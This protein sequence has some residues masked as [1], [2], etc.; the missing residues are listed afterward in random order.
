MAPRAFSDI[1]LEKGNGSSMNYSV[2]EAIRRHR[3]PLTLVRWV[4]LLIGEL[5]YEAR[6]KLAPPVAPPRRSMSGWGGSKSWARPMATVR[7]GPCLSPR[8]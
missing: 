4:R 3:G 8:I 1:N 2:I 5:A 7:L 6:R